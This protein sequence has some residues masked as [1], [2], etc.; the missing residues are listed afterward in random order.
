MHE[1]LAYNREDLDATW[2]VFEWLRSK[3]E[4][5]P[6]NTKQTTGGYMYDVYMTGAPTNNCALRLCSHHDATI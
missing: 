4:A 2:A 3:T 1:I 6:K 5:N